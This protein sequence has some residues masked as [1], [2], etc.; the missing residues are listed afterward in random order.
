VGG[1]RPKGFTEQRNG[2]GPSGVPPVWSATRKLSTWLVCRLIGE[3]PLLAMAIVDNSPYN[4]QPGVAD[5]SGDLGSVGCRPLSESFCPA[6]GRPSACGGLSGRPNGLSITYG[7]LSTVRVRRGRSSPLAAPLGTPPQQP[8]VPPRA[9]A[10]LVR[11][12]FVTRNPALS[13]RPSSF[14]FARYTS[15]WRLG[16][17]YATR[18]DLLPKR[19]LADMCGAGIASLHSMTPPGEQRWSMLVRQERRRDNNTSVAQTGPANL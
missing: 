6:W 3:V 15:F 19:Q 11:S 10:I 5:P 16:L 8:C 17:R 7:G 14:R 1:I 18:Q 2:K 12:G 9:A 13:A 4:H